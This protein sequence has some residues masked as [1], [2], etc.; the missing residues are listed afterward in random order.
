MRDVKGKT[1]HKKN[2]EIDK[3]IKRKVKKT[4][5]NWLNEQCF[6]M[7]EYEKKHDLFNMHKKVRE[8]TG[9]QK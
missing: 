7:E 4:E 1:A 2:K 8:T 9:T 5:E 3:L 6:K